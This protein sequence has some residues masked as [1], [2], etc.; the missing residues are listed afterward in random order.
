MPDFADKYRPALEAQLEP[1]ET[2]NGICAANHRQS[3]FKGRLVAIGVTDRR[4][5]LVGITRRGEPDG[6]EAIA[7][8]QVADAK[9]GDAGDQW[10]N[11]EPS[12]EGVA[13]D[14]TIKTTDGEKLK[15][16]MMR[17]EGK[18]MGKLAGGEFQNQEI[19]ALGRWFEALQ[20]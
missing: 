12:L 17:G 16:T 14:L 18:L 6:V 4:L 10:W 13:V 11:A 1:G 7:P 19:V 3:A 5:L 9:A 20:R 2:L 8:E 15:L